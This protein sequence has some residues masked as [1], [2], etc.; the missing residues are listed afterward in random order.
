[1][2]DERAGLKQ[3]G[4]AGA[5]SVDAEIGAAAS[6]RKARQRVRREAVVGSYSGAEEAAAGVVRSD[7]RIALR[8]L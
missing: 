3:V 4:S 7:D 5:K 1:V 8:R 6:Q 2:P